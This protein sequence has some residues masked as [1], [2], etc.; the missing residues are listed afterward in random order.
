RHHI[1][2]RR[3]PETPAFDEHP[4]CRHHAE[5]AHDDRQ[6]LASWNRRVGWGCRC[7][8]CSGGRAR[9]DYGQTNPTNYNPRPGAMTIWDWIS[10]YLKQ[11]KEENNRERLRLDEFRTQ[12]VK[13]RETDPDS[14]HA[15]Y[16]EG[17]R[18][19]QALG[20]P[21]WESFYELWCVQHL[22]FTK[23]DLRTV[24]DRAVA[25]VLRMRQPVFENFPLRFPI[26]RTFVAAYIYIDPLGYEE[27]ILEAIGHL[28]ADLATREG[29]ED[30]YVVSHDRSSLHFERGE[31]EEV[32]AIALRVLRWADA[33]GTRHHAQTHCLGPYSDLCRITYRTQDWDALANWA[34]LG[35]RLAWKK[36]RQMSAVG[37]TLWQAV[38]A[39]RTG[40]EARGRHLV[41]R[42]TARLNRL[43][44]PPSRVVI[45]ALCNYHALAGDHEA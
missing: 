32:R 41:G 44:V 36:Q 3:S 37:F 20:E 25:H 7:F 17:R 21:W 19:A 2:P 29:G 15:L 26:Q 9:Y 45:D 31:W 38:L 13:L 42:A 39:R 43:G 24:L 11:A 34:E 4:E 40:E 28:E 8:R 5:Q 10:D 16:E 27:Q 18:Y 35:E 33:D 12:A 6:Y 23:A 30:K 1:R 14:A 22:L